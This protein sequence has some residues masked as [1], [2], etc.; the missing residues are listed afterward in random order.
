MVRGRKSVPSKRKTYVQKYHES[1]DGS[2]E[3]RD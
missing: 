1:R 2:K 3:I